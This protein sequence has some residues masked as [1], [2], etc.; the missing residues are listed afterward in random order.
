[1]LIGFDGAD[2]LNGGDGNDVI[3]GGLGVDTIDGGAGNDLFRYTLQNP[4][5]S[6]TSAAISSPG[7]RSARTRSTSTTCSSI[8]A[9]PR[10]DVVGE[11]IMR[12]LVNGNDTLLQ[13][14]KDGGADS[15]VTL[16]M[17][18]NVTNAT[19]ADVIYPQDNG[20]V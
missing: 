8:S 3:E 15:F 11:G 5:T 13:F 10:M 1:M 9:S 2:M 12:L 19:L 17:L 7:S 16:A 4:A 20:V 6:T 18:Q 14:D